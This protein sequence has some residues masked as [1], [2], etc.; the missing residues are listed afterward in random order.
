MAGALK[1]MAE[2]LTDVE[3]KLDQ[4][5]TKIDCLVALLR[6]RDEE[7]QEAASQASLPRPATSTS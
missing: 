2:H 5:L 1:A 3:I 4:A 6:A 7:Q